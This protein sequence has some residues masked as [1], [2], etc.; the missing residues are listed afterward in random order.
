MT[1]YVVATPIGNLSDMTFRA[2]EILKKVDIILAEDT[3]VTRKLL[4]HFEIETKLIS[5]HEYSDE[6]KYQKIFELLES[7]RELALVC[8]AGT[9]AISDPGYFL[10]QQIKQNL[11]EV[12]IT[13]I[14]GA[15]A[16]TTLISVSGVNTKEFT[17]LGFPPHK[18][19][20][21]TFFEKLVQESSIRPIVFYESK[22]RIIKAIESINDILEQDSSLERK[23]TIGR[24]LTKTFEEVIQG[25]SLEILEYLVNNPEKI[26]GEFVIIIS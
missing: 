22:H 7:G 9:P 5:F 16:I 3:R 24:E 25:N 21:K 18:K 17:F 6:K 19:G 26:K 13:P 11:P 23:I 15:S 20:R 14:P 8:D 1:F 2:V 12:K 4:N 10:I